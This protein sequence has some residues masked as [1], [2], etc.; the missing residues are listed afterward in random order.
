[1]S[2][3]LPAYTIYVSVLY[4][5]LLCHF[6][7]FF[8]LFKFFIFRFISFTLRHMHFSLGPSLD[9]LDLRSCCPALRIV[10]PL[11]GT[12]GWMQRKSLLARGL[13]A[14]TYICNCH[15]NFNSLSLPHP[16]LPPLPRFQCVGVSIYCEILKLYKEY[17]NKTTATTTT[18]AATKWAMRQLYLHFMQKNCIANPP[19]AV[20]PQFP[21]LILHTQFPFPV[22]VPFRFRIPVPVPVPWQVPVRLSPWQLSISQSSL[23]RSLKNT[24]K[25]LA[26]WTKS[27]ASELRDTRVCV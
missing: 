19:T 15:S 27:D 21:F 2:A 22:P 4:L 23:S 5:Y 17:L 24:T 8:P 13:W 10:K 18:I 20:P 3:C 16:T 6:S 11:F 12:G 26:K 25:K 7:H 14:W 9:G 1:M